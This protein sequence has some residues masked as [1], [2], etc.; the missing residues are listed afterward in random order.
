MFTSVPVYALMLTHFGQNWGFLT[1]LNLMPTYMN[2]V[3]HIHVNEVSEHCREAMNA[4]TDFSRS[5]LASSLEHTH[6]GTSLPG[7]SLVWLDSFLD[8]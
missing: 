8:Q 6:L 1:V 2:N 4:Q 5:L 3:L 7:T